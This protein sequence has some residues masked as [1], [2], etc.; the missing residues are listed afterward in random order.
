MKK[1]IIILIALSF[2]SVCLAA[3][4]QDM[5]KA[6]I[7]RRNVGGAE[8]V[9]TDNFD[10]GA[11][12][13]DDRALWGSNVIYSNNTA[14]PNDLDLGSNI[15]TR[16]E[17]AGVKEYILFDSIP[18]DADYSVQLELSAS[19]EAADYVL[20]GCVR[21]AVGG[22][23][24]TGYYAD[25]RTSS[26]LF[27]FHRM[28]NGTPTELLGFTAIAAQDWTAMHLVKLD[29]SGSGTGTTLKLYI[30]TDTSEGNLSLEETYVD[31][32]GSAIDAKGQAGIVTYNKDTYSIYI[33]NFEVKD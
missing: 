11:G 3:S 5:H 30:S 16:S 10:G 14:R 27:R 1:L 6:A 4:I 23:G 31:D 29:I 7:A 8:T 22:T 26:D 33:D 28:D 18:T 2:V 13:L 12:Q 20:S 17:Y 15:L 32:S 24:M 19:D 25:I 21:C 9:W